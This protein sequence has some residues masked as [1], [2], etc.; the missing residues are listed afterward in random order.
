MC[1]HVSSWAGAGDSHLLGHLAGL[2]PPPSHITLLECRVLCN[3]YISVFSSSA[4]CATG[5]N[6]MSSKVG[7]HFS[8]L[9]SLNIK[10]Q[11]IILFAS[12]LSHILITWRRRDSFL[13]SISTFDLRDLHWCENVVYILCLVAW[14]ESSLSPRVP[15]LCS[16]WQ[17]IQTEW[18]LWTKN[19]KS[20]LLLISCV[21]LFQHCRELR[22]PW[23]LLGPALTKWSPR[24]GGLYTDICICPLPPY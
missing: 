10:G 20:K 14:N 6:S 18:L 2:L 9:T 21:L 15:G 7:N 1:L 22:D 16:C 4:L 11:K 3:V 5:C 8:I 12:N 13:M 19:I 24:T 17:L 23:P